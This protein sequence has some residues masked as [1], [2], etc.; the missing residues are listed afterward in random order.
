MPGRVA[1]GRDRERVGRQAL[2]VDHVDVA[3]RRRGTEEPAE[4]LRIGL[5]GARVVEQL[6]K[7]GTLL[8]AR[9]CRTPERVRSR[10]TA[11]G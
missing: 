6:A 8:L 3:D 7:R 4:R 11:H 9:R 1:D 5:V 2:V 10:P